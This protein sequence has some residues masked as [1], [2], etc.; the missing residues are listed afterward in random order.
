MTVH[1]DASLLQGNTEAF[2]PHA[3]D[4][5][6]DTYLALN[7]PYPPVRKL[8]QDVETQFGVSLKN[9]GEAHITVVT[10]I[11]YQTLASC[12][13]IEAINRMVAEEIQH[14]P[15][16][17]LC[18]GRATATLPSG[19]ESAYF[20]VVE[21]PGLRQVRRT[22]VEALVEAGGDPA[23]FD[24]EGYFPH[25]TVGFS[26]RDLHERDGAVKDESACVA[27]VRVMQ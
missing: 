13:D 25:V 14:V 26:A 10:P 11:E 8:L 6:F 22:I 7:L 5:P 2:I 15:F 20:L 9:R 4:G 3:G 1:V 16:E 21:A 23:V 27:Q 24:P 18:L 12:L 19:P 17:I